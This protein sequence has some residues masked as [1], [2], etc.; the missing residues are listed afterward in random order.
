MIKSDFNMKRRESANGLLKNFTQMMTSSWQK[1]LYRNCQISPLNGK[2]CV[3][4]LMPFVMT[5]LSW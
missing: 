1:L 3:I 5:L 2:H 4:F